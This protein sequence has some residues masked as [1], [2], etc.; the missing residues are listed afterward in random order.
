MSEAE[1]FLKCLVDPPSGSA[2]A[3]WLGLVLAT[4]HLWYLNVYRIQRTQDLFIRRLYEGAF[5]EQ[6]LLFNTRFDIQTK[7][8][9]KR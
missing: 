9:M 1:I 7:D 5:I 8:R 2:V 6:S 3:W 4:L